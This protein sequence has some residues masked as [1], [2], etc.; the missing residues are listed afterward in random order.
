MP[1]KLK[2]NKT[3]YGFKEA[4]YKGFVITDSDG[5]YYPKGISVNIYG[6]ITSVDSLKDA[7]KIIHELEKRRKA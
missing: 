5:S 7:I 4:E 6:D 1:T 2:W 3:P